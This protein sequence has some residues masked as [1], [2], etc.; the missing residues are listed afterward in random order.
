MFLT[1]RFTC[2]SLTY[3]YLL[4]QP[5]GLSGY[6]V[7]L[8]DSRLLLDKLIPTYVCARTIK[9]EEGKG[10]T[11]LRF[12]AFCLR[13]AGNRRVNQN[14]RQATYTI[15]VTFPFRLRDMF[16]SLYTLKRIPWATARRHCSWLLINSYGN[17]GMSLYC[18]PI[19]SHGNVYSS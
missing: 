8:S 5:D 10:R 16:R 15:I 18:Q 11:L 4:T 19:S 12:A 3:I 1:D 9:N 13:F 7:W 17:N 2:P 6:L 14:V